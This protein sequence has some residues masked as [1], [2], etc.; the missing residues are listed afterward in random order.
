MSTA[1]WF[2][3]S[4]GDRAI[5][6]KFISLETLGI[7][8]IAF[9][10]ASFPMAL[11]YA[12]N[13]RLMIPVYRDMQQNRDPAAI[14]KQRLLRFGLTSG[15]LALLW[16]IAL[17]GPWL[18]DVL[19]DDRYILAGAIIVPLAL[20][21]APAVIAMTYD[22]SALA[23]GDSR[24]FFAVSAVRAVSQTTLILAGVYWFGLPGVILAM[25]AGLLATY[26]LIVYL[27]L[28]HKVWG[29]VT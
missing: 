20:V 29:L 19:Y 5:L 23:A 26:P 27:A 9:F 13:Q 6:G 18:V 15:I 2:L 7:Y 22:Q 8:N 17:I 4:Q 11:G 1:F 21:L 24:L 28:K 25:G 16:T 12:V 10:L 14:R 3:T